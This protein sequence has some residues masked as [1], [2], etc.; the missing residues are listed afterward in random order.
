MRSVV[1]RAVFPLSLVLSLGLGCGGGEGFPSPRTAA[2]ATR[3][4]GAALAS[5]GAELTRAEDEGR[6]LEPSLDAYLAGLTGP[7]ATLAQAIRAP[8]APQERLLVLRLAAGEIGAATLAGARVVDATRAGPPPGIAADVLVLA[9]AARAGLE[10][11]VLVDAGQ[12]RHGFPKDPLAS[13]TLGL[14]PVLASAGPAALEAEVAL[15]AGVRAALG[16]AARFDYVAAARAAD[17]LRAR[18]PGAP[19]GASRARARLALRLLDSAGLGLEQ[20]AAADE[21]PP[22]KEVDPAPSERD[23]PYAHLV[24][25]RAA[26]EPGA[27]WAGRR[28][29]I[30][31]ALPAERRAHTEAYFAALGECSPPLALPPMERAADLLFG[32]TL[33]SSALP[34]GA[35][36]EERKRAVELWLA[37]YG[38]YAELVERTGTTWLSAPLLLHRRGEALG[39]SPEGTPT[40]ERVTR[41]GLAHLEALSRLAAAEPK[42]FAAM[43]LVPLAQSP[44]A[45]RDGKLAPALV[46]LTQRVTEAKLAAAV[47]AS[48]LASASL[49]AGLGSMSLPPGVREAQLAALD[50]SL[51][52]ALRGPLRSESGWSAAG[53]YVAHAAA[54]LVASQPADLRFTAAEVERALAQESDLPRLAALATVAARY[55]GLA[56]EGRLDP[57]QRDEARFAPDRRAA[58][59]ALRRALVGLGAPG[60]A[61]AAAVDELATLADG[62]IAVLAFAAT[63]RDASAPVACAGPSYVELPPAVARS[64]AKLGDVRRKVLASPRLKAGKDEW[65]RHARV[66]ALVL[67]D[68][69]DVLQKKGP[70]V[71]FVVSSE[72]A[73]RYLAEALSELDERAAADGLGAAYGLVRGYLGSERGEAFLLQNGASW[74]RLFVAIAAFLRSGGSEGSAQLFETMGGRAPLFAQDG[75]AQLT[76]ELVGYAEGLYGAGQK[77]HGDLLLIA[78]LAVG[79]ARGE[80]LPARALALADAQNSRAAW[81]LR[82]EGEITEASGRRAPE[83]QRFAEALRSTSSLTCEPRGAEPV[84]EVFAAMKSFAAGDRAQARRALDAWLDDADKR[85]LVLPKVA[86]RFEETGTRVFQV[87]VDLS[88]GAG[89]VQASTFQLGLG[90]RNEGDAGSRLDVTRGANTDEEA[91]RY[92]VHVAALAAAYHFLDGD[93]ARG[94]RDAQRVLG[95]ALGGTRLGGKVVPAVGEHGLALDSRPTV[96]VVAQ[97]AAEARMPFL[98]GDLWTVVR[99]TFYPTL[100]DV[101]VADILSRPPLGLAGLAESSA[102]LERTRRAL[103]VLAEP[104]ACTA[105]KVDRSAYDYPACELYPQALA[106]RVA[107][108][109]RQMPRL[110]TTSGSAARACASEAAVDRFLVQKEQGTYDPDAFTAAVAQAEAAGHTYDAAALLTRQR[111]EPH[112]SAAVLAAARRLG[113]SAELGPSLRADL[114]SVAVNCGAAELDAAA[115]A[116]LSAVDDALALLP[117]P[118]RGFATL[119]STLELADRTERWDV[120]ARLVDKP[121]FLTRWTGTTPFAATAALLIEQASGTLVGK[122]RDVAATAADV[123]LFCETFPPA[124]RAETCTWLRTLRSQAGAPEA[125]RKASARSALRALLKQ[126]RR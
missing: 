83:P 71:S 96:A 101:D 46:A 4:A 60:E 97:L 28:T 112:C 24:L 111:A 11:V 117:D 2:Q 93:A 6:P 110:A 20:S 104:L 5:C 61:P 119:L 38:A 15:A 115:V 56:A 37:R 85:G 66:L 121:G 19:H 67:S 52:E 44:G 73:T 116:D 18:L 122:P 81:A 107:D 68:T 43:T 45:L 54:R 3:C 49:T 88:F 8:A 72:E 33:V 32:W 13:M 103:R 94:A 27:A 77:D 1:A 7:W 126:V 70:A 22:P 21:S 105:A 41:L 74:Q 35:S 98:A 39:L 30:L 106:L 25:M 55:G 89:L 82:F 108:A 9:L 109:T 57:E 42:R 118:S 86:F 26:R 80:P 63:S 62:L 14:R 92:Y 36:P 124:D 123:G 51:G 16:A 100:S 59:D 64:L 23:T 120:L 17:A 48:E 53:L 78:G 34:E 79:A 95:A 12:I 50:R 47:T 99:D 114:L 125:D 76:S 10:H 84:L 90:L 40:H 29:P 102:L 58:K 31:A 113:H 65:S 69:L 87:S 91:A 75:A